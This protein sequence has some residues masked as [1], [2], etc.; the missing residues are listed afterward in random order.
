M[1]QGLSMTIKYVT[2]QLQFSN[3]HVNG[4]KNHKRNIRQTDIFL[5]TIGW[6]F[7]NEQQVA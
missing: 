7:Y 4:I 2:Y 1:Q 6:A 5:P 3:S